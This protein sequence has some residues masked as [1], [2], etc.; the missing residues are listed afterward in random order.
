MFICG[1]ENI[2]PEEVEAALKRHPAILDAI[3]FGEDTPSLVYCR[4]PFCDIE[5]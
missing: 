4:P 1:G 3:V 2:Q 5:A